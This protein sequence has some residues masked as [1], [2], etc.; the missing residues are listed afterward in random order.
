MGKDYQAFVEQRDHQMSFVG[1]KTETAGNQLL[2]RSYNKESN[3]FDIQLGKDFGGFKNSDDKY[4]QGKV[5]FNCHKKHIID[6][7]N[8]HNS[9]LSFKIIK[10]NGRYSLYDPFELQYEE[11][12]EMTCSRYGVIGLDFNKVL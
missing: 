11:R 6:I 7:L 4:A 9:P 1:T 5:Y 12:N 10:R 2:Q 3:Q 8:K